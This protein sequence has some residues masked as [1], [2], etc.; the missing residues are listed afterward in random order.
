M[1]YVPIRFRFASK[2]KIYLQHDRV[3]RSTE[4]A[5]P[6]LD[7]DGDW[8]DEKSRHDVS[9]AFALLHGLYGTGGSNFSGA[10]LRA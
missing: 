1:I 9:A 4:I 2:T 8:Q 5:G 10:L 6:R 3:N 7:D